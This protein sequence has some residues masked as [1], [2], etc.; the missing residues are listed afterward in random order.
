MSG[1]FEVCVPAAPLYRKASRRSPLETQLVY[2]E[3]FKA[4]QVKRG[5]AAGQAQSPM[6][7]SP[8]PGYAGHIPMAYLRAL[9]TQPNVIITALSAP[10]FK[11]ADIKS[12]VQGMWPMNARFVGRLEEDFFVTDQGA[13]H[14]RHARHIEQ[15]PTETDYVAIAERHIG[16]P[17]IWGGVVSDGL[18]CSGLVQSSLRAAGRDAPRDSA[19]QEHMGADIPNGKELR[20]GDLVFWKGHVGI[21]QDG[22]N[23]LHANAFHMSVASEP[24]ETAIARISEPVTGF[25]RID[26]T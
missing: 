16:R 4:S 23:L 22:R 18:D 24:L 26:K 21:M 11:T 10:I 7:N 1:V 20:R 5:W 17:Y 25:R 19:D 3:V 2:G 9:D 14:R 6:E 13:I 12:P 15:S 8:F